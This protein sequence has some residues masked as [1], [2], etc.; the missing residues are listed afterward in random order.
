MKRLA[1]LPI[2]LILC[3]CG[4]PKA[5]RCRTSAPKPEVTTT[6]LLTDAADSWRTLG[7]QPSQEARDCYNLVIAQLFDKLD[8]GRGGWNENASRIGTVIDRSH[9]LG[10]RLTLEDLDALVPASNVKIK[11]MGPRF[12]DEGIGL[13]LVGWKSAKNIDERRFKF[14]PPSGIPLNLTAILDFSKSPPTWRFLFR[15]RVPEIEINQR[16]E[17][18]AVDWSASSAL[19]WHM[20]NLDD[21]DLTKVLMP[22]RHVDQ[23]GLFFTTPYDPEKIPVILAHGL[24]SSP[25]TYKTL[26]NHLI[27]QKWFRDQYQIF[28]FS[29][30]TGTAWP[31]NAAEFRKHLRD[32]QD[33]VKSKG[34]LTKWN[35]MVLIGHSMGGVIS[36]AS[37]VEPEDRFYKAVYSRPLDAYRLSDSAKKAIRSVRFYEPLQAPTRAV[38]MAA[39]L[40]G[41]PMA[42]R[43]FAQA[44]SKLI[45]LPKTLTI[46][47]AT[48]TVAEVTA[49]M[50]QGGRPRPPMTS[51]GTLS[52][53]YKSYEALKNSPFR[54]GLTYHTIIGDRGKNNSPNSSDGIVPY[55]SSHLK[56]AES[57][58]IVPE[59]HSLTSHPETIAEINR[60]LRLHLK[61]Q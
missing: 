36:C 57:E 25:G 22:T 30:P 28:L 18:V 38:F 48:A 15:G 24:Y 56:G 61:E 17:A 46:D 33:H 12:T 41:S 11:D 9:T 45:R 13:P 55:W 2:L 19:Y 8:C 52:P 32:V 54:D 14:A 7:R 10:T 50:E 16:K 21:L 23:A 27:S 20:S 47:L 51:I 42:D 1:L 34:P 58:K 60:I 37:L 4:A 3:Q 35:R 49:A 53:K 44:I 26:Y 29:Y 39:P 59:G 43:F 31:Y 40:Q 6:E 5:P